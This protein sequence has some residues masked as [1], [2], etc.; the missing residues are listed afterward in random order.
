MR[1]WKGGKVKIVAVKHLFNVKTLKK[2]S[3]VYKLF[4]GFTLDIY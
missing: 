3:V 2:N 4:A 1:M